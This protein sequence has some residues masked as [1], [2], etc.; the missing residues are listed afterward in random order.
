MSLASTVSVLLSRFVAP[1][2]LLAL[3]LLHSLPATANGGESG[4]VVEAERAFFHPIRAP[5]LTAASDDDTPRGV[6]CN[7][8]CN[9]KASDCLDECEEKFKDDA[10]ARVTCKFECAT[11]RQQCEKNCGE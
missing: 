1:S 6:S 11:K 8:D 5:F 2:A 7:E 10:K 3:G 9:R 4:N